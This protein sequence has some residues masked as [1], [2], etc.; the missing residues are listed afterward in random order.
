MI[1]MKAQAFQVAIAYALIHDADNTIAQLNK[2][3]DQHEGQIL[4]I[5]YNPFFD[6]VRSDP[7]FVELEK[8]VGLM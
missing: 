4:Y 1:A 5:K 6:E 2:S 8:R 7:R 3:A